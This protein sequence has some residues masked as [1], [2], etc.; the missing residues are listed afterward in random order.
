MPDQLML[1]YFPDVTKRMIGRCFRC[2]RRLYETDR[3]EE[4]RMFWHGPNGGGVDFTYDCGCK[5]RAFVARF[6]YGF[7]VVGEEL[8]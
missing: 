4:H 3:F 2:N 7:S 6:L 1:P 5:S 8:R